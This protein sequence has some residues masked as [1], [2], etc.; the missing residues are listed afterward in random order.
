M[1][2]SRSRFTLG[3]GWLN[4]RQQLQSLAPGAVV[5][6]FVLLLLR[7]GAWE[8]GEHSAYRLLFRLRGARA[9]DDR[10][11]VV[12][13]DD[14]S[15]Q[16]LGR[17]PWGRDRYA[18]LLD[19][20]LP[21]QPA[22]VGFSILMSEVVTEDPAGDAAFAEAL[23]IS[24]NGV[25]AAAINAPIP[26]S[27]SLQAGGPLPAQSNLPP[28]GVLP[29]DILQAQ[30]SSGH[31]LQSRDADGISRQNHL[32]AGKFPTLGLSLVKVYNWQLESTIGQKEP[33]VPIAL[34]PEP[35][36][37]V[38]KQGLNTPLWINWPGPSGEDQGPTSYS[39]EEVISGNVD[40]SRFTNKI[41]LVGVRLTGADP[42]Y[43]P[44]DRNPPTSGVYLH[45]A[46]V[47]NVLQGRA[48]RRWPPWATV[49]LVALAGPLLGWILGGLPLRRRWLGVVIALVGWGLLCPIAF[50][51]NL[52]LPVVAPLMTLILTGGVSLL[53]KQL[54]TNAQ[55]QA[56]SELLATMSH[57][58]RTPMNAVI[59]MTGLL[60]DTPLNGEQ[61]GFAN[62]IRSSSESLLTLINDILD[63]SKIESGQLA[64][65][66]SPFDL[67]RCLEDCLDLVAA[68]AAQAG[69]ELSYW[70]DEETPEVIAGDIT[71]LRQILVN[72][73][74]NAVKF[75]EQGQV[76]IRVHAQTI[77]PEAE[78]GFSPQ[79]VQR[80]FQRLS[81]KLSQAQS[82]LRQQQ[83]WVR[84]YPELLEL[85]Q[86]YQ[87]EFAVEDTGIGIPANRLDRL[88]KPFSQ[89]DASTT[90]R[91]G[92]T[93]LGLVISDRL[94]H[95]LGG[96][97]GVFTRD[98]EG[99]LGQ[100]GRSPVLEVAERTAQGSTFHFS[101]L[102][103]SISTVATEAIAT[104]LL[105]GKRLLIVDDNL[106]NR[107]IL[108]LQAQ[109]WGMVA[110]VAPSGVEALRLLSRCPDYDLAI[111]DQQ[112]PEMD[113]V[114]LVQRLRLRPQLR[115]LPLIFLT[116]LGSQ[117]LKDHPIQR[118]L[119]AL[120]TKP[121]KQTQLYEVVCRVLKI[122]GTEVAP[123]VMGSA[124]DGA[125][126]EQIPLRILLAEDNRVNQQVTLKLLSRLGYRADVAASGDEVLQAFQRQYYDLVL[127]D[128]Q[129]PLMDG[130][131]ATQHL[132]QELLKQPYIIAL[133]ASALERDREACYAAGMDA[134][135]SKPFRIQELLDAIRAI[136]RQDG[137]E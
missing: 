104:E 5:S 8:V 19:T 41:V 66:T 125:L 39:F 86:L 82:I 133:T 58:I 38:V 26:A 103:P 96:G 20:L 113:G 137:S 119:A 59:G 77:S 76:T 79:F 12:K 32:Y 31:V 131:E 75:T 70:M 46:V 28:Q 61:Q 88:F 72:L 52:W 83:D 92:G 68:P 120:L 135:L 116:S 130:L 100:T 107:Q 91:Y 128:V 24:G 7:L 11:V 80:R 110:D 112:M 43:T 54:Q 25:L 60:L 14:A 85:G 99:H 121:V 9:W 67:R 136:P 30:A 102:A 50:Q 109:G 33:F 95:L 48:L 17:Y 45:A 84:R 2:R 53:Q 129:M 16:Q 126:A 134:Y 90:R 69:I 44:F 42:I 101:L 63:F 29:L 6:L 78:A 97:M 15:V 35:D 36:A 40:L 108:T 49:V 93:G 81:G 56:R 10:I 132:R 71:R 22:V 64:L 18:D 111:L 3:L 115:S 21:A 4:L 34:P 106:T 74:S 105:R 94:S 37:A 23:R 62:V 47:D 89:V 65:E 55:L 73:L 1:R 124:I 117:E 57:E 98:A 122:E 27:R 123:S 114:E 13:I 51:F 118:E 127:M 87:I